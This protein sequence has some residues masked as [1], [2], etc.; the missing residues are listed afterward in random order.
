MPCFDLWAAS[1]APSQSSLTAHIQKRPG[2][3]SEPLCPPLLPG[4]LT[5][6]QE[7][8][9]KGRAPPSSKLLPCG[10]ARQML[11]CSAHSFR[12]GEESL[13]QGRRKWGPSLSST[14]LSVQSPSLWGVLLRAISLPE[15]FLR[16]FVHKATSAQLSQ[17]P[18]K[19][20]QQNV[21]QEGPEPARKSY[22]VAL[23]VYLIPPQA[24]DSPL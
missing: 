7:E 18:H 10:G 23:L 3:E 5:S 22:L 13:G 17:L 1:F 12:A 19:S 11:G 9:R 20:P 4:R 6:F 24:M 21:I 16:P 2:Q 8:P 15:L 14:F